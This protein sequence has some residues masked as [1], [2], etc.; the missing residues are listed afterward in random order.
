MFQDLWAKEPPKNSHIIQS[1]DPTVALS[2]SGQVTSPDKIK[3]SYGATFG[4]SG[5]GANAP[6]GTG[7]SQKAF[8]MAYF[9]NGKYHVKMRNQGQ[10][11]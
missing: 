6:Y 2:W 9:M 10:Y 11:L 3:S 5:N 7:V 8:D 1:M 4:G